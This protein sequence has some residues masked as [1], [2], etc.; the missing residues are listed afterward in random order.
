MPIQQAPRKIIYVA[1][2]LYLFLS[3]FS[4]IE[5]LEFSYHCGITTIKGT[6]VKILSPWVK[7]TSASSTNTF[8]D[9][10]E[11]EGIRKTRQEKNLSTQG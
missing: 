3:N 7:H 5:K 1:Q 8:V 2:T 6:P 11:T 9:D 10:R 4:S